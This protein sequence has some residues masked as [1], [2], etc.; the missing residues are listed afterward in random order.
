MMNNILNNT[1]IISGNNIKVAKYMNKQELDS[2]VEK[3]RRCR[4]YIKRLPMNFDN[5]AL[6][7]LFSKYGK[8]SKAYSVNGTKAR[9]NLKYGY[10]LFEEES[11][12]D[13]LPL[14]GVLY[15]NTKLV[16][17]C[18]KHKLEKRK[19]KEIQDQQRRIRQFNTVN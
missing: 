9:K 16:W 12:I 3:S 6:V 13:N 14:D 8:V 7:R 2:Y 5:D 18:Y 10:V 1:Q 17:T 19:I 11:S 15:H 4:I